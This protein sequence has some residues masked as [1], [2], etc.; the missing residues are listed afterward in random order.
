MRTI[1]AHKFKEQVA[2]MTIRD[3]LPVDKANAMIKLIDM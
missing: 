2:A 3:D 1:D